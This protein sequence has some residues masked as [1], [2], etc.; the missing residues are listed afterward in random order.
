MAA[1]FFT[2]VSIVFVCF[3]VYR[4]A[5]R[6]AKR[7]QGL[8]GRVRHSLGIVVAGPER[9]VGGPLHRKSL[10]VKRLSGAVFR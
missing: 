10:P 6:T 7:G 9:T 5:S 2:A 8:S 1:V 3:D 4:Q